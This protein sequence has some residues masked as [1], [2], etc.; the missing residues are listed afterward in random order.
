[1]LTLNEARTV[2]AWV[3]TA[4]G[5]VLDEAWGSTEGYARHRSEKYLGKRRAEYGDMRLCRVTV[6][7]CTDEETAR[8]RAEF[9]EWKA[10][11]DGERRGLEGQ[12]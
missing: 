10:A 11:K 12:P 2:W 9:V 8:Y 6:T 1:M 5:L 3:C 7:P 4:T